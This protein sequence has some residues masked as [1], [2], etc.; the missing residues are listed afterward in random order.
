M[1]G[2]VS[3]KSQADERAAMEDATSIATEAI[4]SIKTVQSLGKIT[5]IP[6][7]LRTKK[8]Q[9]NTRI[10]NQSQKKF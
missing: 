6:F 10:V 8:T 3:Q 5:L 1:E 7:F 9:C 2:I 4:V